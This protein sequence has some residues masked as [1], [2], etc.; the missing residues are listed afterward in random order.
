MG[1][2]M[3]DY[4]L[5]EIA[6]KLKQIEEAYSTGNSGLYLFLLESIGGDIYAYNKKSKHKIIFY[7]FFI[8]PTHSNNEILGLA[9]SFIKNLRKQLEDLN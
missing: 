8:T 7:Q 9:S 6:K 2:I 1:E 3:N 4:R 5:N